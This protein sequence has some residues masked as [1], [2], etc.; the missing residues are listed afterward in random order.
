MTYCNFKLLE[1]EKKAQNGM[2]NY[3]Y[4]HLVLL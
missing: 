2:Q 4:T 1:T 3:V